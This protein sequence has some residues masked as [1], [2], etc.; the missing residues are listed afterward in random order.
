MKKIVHYLLPNEL[1]ELAGLAKWAESLPEYA[2]LTPGTAY[3]L[4]LALEE[5][6]SNIIKYGFDDQSKHDIEIDL[7]FLPDGDVRVTLRDDGH[8]FNPFT[9]AEKTEITEDVSEQDF[10]GMGVFLVKSMSREL[11]YS[12]ENNVNV[13]SFVVMKK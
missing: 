7:E 4:Q 10:G 13:V 9:E 1:S 6:V 2:A 11:K 12:R 8:E 5:M 3:S